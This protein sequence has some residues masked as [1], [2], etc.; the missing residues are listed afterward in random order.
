MNKQEIWNKIQGV[1]PELLK[2]KTLE[3]VT[4]K[5]LATL[6]R[7]AEEVSLD[8]IRTMILMALEG[9][10]A[11]AWLRTVYGSYIIY[12]LAEKYYK[13]PYSI[14]E[15]VVQFGDTPT[16]VEKVWVEK[17]SAQAETDEEFETL[18]RLD[19]AK[20]AERSAWEVTIC[21]PGFTKNGWYFPE[22]VIRNA[23]GLFE[24][25]EVNLY[26]LPEQGGTHV[27]DAL[28]PIKNLL[29]KNKAGWIDGVRFVAGQGLKGVL[30]FL[31]SA[32]WLGKNMVR[33]VQDGK[34]IYGLSFDC[35]TRAR[36]STVQG[37]S[38]FEAIEIK[39][40]DSVDIVT[41]PAAGGKFDRAIAGLSTNSKE[42]EVMNKQELWDLINGAR[43]DL[44]KGKTLDGVSDEDLSVLARMAMTPADDGGGDGDTGDNG[45][46]DTP[47]T[48]D[49]LALFRCSMDLDAALAGS[50]LPDAAQARVRAAF[51]D[52]IFEAS[53]LEKAINEEKDYIAKMSQPA[54]DGADPVPA[55]E[56]LVV[57]LG[58]LERAQMAVDKLFGLTREDMTGMA[59]MKRLDNQS[60]FEDIRSKQD[61]EGFDDV[62]GFRGIR[63]MY[64]FFTGDSEVTGRFNPK[65]MSADLR[66]GSMA[67]TSSTFS[68]VIGNT[69]G[70]RLV[71]DYL[72]QNFHEDLLISIR[73][74]AKDF[75]QQEAVLVGYFGDLDTVDPESGD[76][77]EISAVTDEESTY[78]IAQKGNILTITRKTIIN[79]DISLIQRLVS[80]MGRAAR[81]THA[82]Y[83]WDFFVNNSNCSDGT[84]WF[85][86]AGAHVNLG[87]TALD[88]ATA[89][90]AYKAL[91]GMTEKDSGEKIGLL[92]DPSVTPTLV[93]PVDLM[94]S[95]E[96]VVEDDHYYAT[97]DLTDKTRNP[98]KGKIAG[99]MV[100]LLSDANDWGLLMPPGVVD[101]VEMGYL[102]GRQ[103]PEM[104]VADSPQS[105]QVFVADK[106]RHKIRHEYA[107]A[108]IDFR[109]GYKSV[110]A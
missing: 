97:N 38:V 51:G 79:D 92:D 36:K 90:T 85:T 87:S 43:P 6:A 35:P 9:R 33:A 91:A 37:R 80:R 49:D 1:R 84:A 100:S 54:E 81:R 69:L 98:L 107:G 13:L 83:V 41:R 31:D 110:V 62:P 30:H 29:V 18:L 5:E 101:M 56:T 15:G 20:D 45:D 55:S 3:A 8:D 34:S 106:I 11:N 78:T 12:E 44:L 99:A 108:V 24:N 96:S 103:E 60:F 73:K 7:M 109:S 93:Y 26:E 70:R 53:G 58:T 46:G 22:S 66:R 10:D 74:S 86:G 82:K 32:K 17:R 71:K 48:Q 67:V 39:A 61:I 52:R 23:A 72:A 28:F 19:A 14:L 88:F 105:E 94:E 50:D 76:Y 102:N 77:Q 63:E 68:Y 4:E 64:T 75:R 16:E 57:G 65:K 59:D 21:E 2:G 25:V 89:I 42:D 40:A 27:P 95:G 47:V 104:F